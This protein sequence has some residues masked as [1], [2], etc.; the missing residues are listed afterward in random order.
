MSDEKI[1][2]FPD[3]SDEYRVN[4]VAKNDI[5]KYFLFKIDDALHV[6]QIS[7]T[8]ILIPPLAEDTWQFDSELEQLSY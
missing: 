8:R 7:N 1:V 5:R 2:T 6:G 4:K 3:A